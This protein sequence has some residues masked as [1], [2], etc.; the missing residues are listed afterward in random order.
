ML[1]YTINNLNQF[2]MDPDQPFQIRRI[3]EFKKVKHLVLKIDLFNLRIIILK[4]K[5][6]NG[7]IEMKLRCAFRRSDITS[8][9]LVALEKRYSQYFNSY[10]NES[11]EE[12]STSVSNGSAFVSQSQQ[13]Q[14]APFSSASTSYLSSLTQNLSSQQT[15]QLKHHELFYSK[16]IE[17]DAPIENIRGKLELNLFTNDINT[18]DEYLGS[19]SENKFFYQMNYDPNQKLISFDRGLIRVGA[20]YQADIPAY[21]SKVTASYLRKGQREDL[22]WDGPRSSSLIRENILR[23]FVKK[24]LEKMSDAKNSSGRSSHVNITNDKAMVDD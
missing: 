13:Q 7:N 11:D 17:F 6:E 3:E 16:Y 21:S 2:R 24:A 10:K 4:L 12:D 20:K 8:S 23:S 18:S 1:V 5:K 15:Y 9:L 19:L 22:L 14:Q